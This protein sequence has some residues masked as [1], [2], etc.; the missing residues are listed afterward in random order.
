MVVSQVNGEY[1][2]NEETMKEYLRIVKSLRTKFK[3]C[4][5]KH[6]PREETIKFVAF[7]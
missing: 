6:I 7:I 4:H 3:E 1:E 5:I 2:A